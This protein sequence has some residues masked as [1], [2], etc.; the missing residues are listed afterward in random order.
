MEKTNMRLPL[1]SAP[2]NRTLSAA[3]LTGDGVEAS[4]DWSSLAK[5]VAHVA[6]Q[7]APVIAGLL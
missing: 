6:A 2:V 1:Q 7:A 5:T 4:F 3:A